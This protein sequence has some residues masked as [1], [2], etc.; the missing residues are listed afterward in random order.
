MNASNEQKTFSIYSIFVCNR[1][2]MKDHFTILSH[3]NIRPYAQDAHLKA[4]FM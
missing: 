1:K 2:K 4:F 3:K